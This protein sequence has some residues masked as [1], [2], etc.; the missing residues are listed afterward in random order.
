MTLSAVG[1][2]IC[3]LSGLAE[4]QEGEVKGHIRVGRLPLNAAYLL[5]SATLWSCVLEFR[6]HFARALSRNHCTTLRP[7]SVI[8]PEEP[9][10]FVPDGDSESKEV[11]GVTY[12][13][14][15]NPSPGCGARAG[16]EKQRAE[17]LLHFS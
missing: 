8:D 1:F 10:S 15:S 11:R 2:M 17:V 6:L 3:G 9:H 13:P 7:R 14:E 12:F 4:V 16:V 5:K